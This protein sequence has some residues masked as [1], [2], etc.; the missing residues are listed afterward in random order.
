MGPGYFFLALHYL[1]LGLALYAL[2]DAAVRP[3]AAWAY[4]G[5][6]RGLWLALL[7][8]ATLI[9]WGTAFALGL[10]AIAAVIVSLVYLL[11][12][13]PKLRQFSGTRRVSGRGTGRRMR[14][15]RRRP[16]LPPGPSPWS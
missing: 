2:V 10:F 15:P 9:A 5:V 16:T 7:A 3:R 1:V 13:R 14:R 11:E 6:R 4:A 12:Q 8:G